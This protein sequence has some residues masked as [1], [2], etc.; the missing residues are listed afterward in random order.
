MEWAWA[1]KSIYC[2]C[3]KIDWQRVTTWD[4]WR[5]QRQHPLELILYMVS[6]LVTLE[7][8]FCRRYYLNYFHVCSVFHFTRDTCIP[9]IVYHTLFHLLSISPLALSLSTLLVIS[10]HSLQYRILTS[11]YTMLVHIPWSLHFTIYYLY[12]RRSYTSWAPHFAIH[13]LWTHDAHTYHR[14]LPVWSSLRLPQ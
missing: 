13:H 8:T 2:A 6:S 12:T 14:L 11:V 1:T 3:I 10:T 7:V 5:C 9:F 4:R